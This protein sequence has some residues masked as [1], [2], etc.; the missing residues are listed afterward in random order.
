M[1]GRFKAKSGAPSRWRRLTT[2]YAVGRYL[3]AGKTVGLSQAGVFEEKEALGVQRVVATHDDSLAG[4]RVKAG[5]A[6]DWLEIGGA[7]RAPD[8]RR[9]AGIVVPGC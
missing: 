2:Q 1:A 4:T 9:K 3:R 6:Q 5:T 8:G 7:L